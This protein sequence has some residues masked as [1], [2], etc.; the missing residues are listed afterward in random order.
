MLTAIACIISLFVI[1]HLILYFSFKKKESA[2][3]NQV[4][5]KKISVVI[6]AKNE[7][8]NIPN[9]IQSINNLNYPP[10]KFEIIFI[11]D[12]SSDR[13]FEMLNSYSLSKNN[14]KVLRA[15]NKKYPLKKG[16]VDLGIVNSNYEFIVTTD[17]DCSLPPN[18]LKEFSK[19]FESYDVV[20]GTVTII[21]N[22]HPVNQMACFENLRSR[23]LAVSLGKLGLPYTSSGGSFGYRKSLYYSVG[24]FSNTLNTAS[25]DD[26]LLLK[27]FISKQASV[28]FLKS[29]N[30]LVKTNSP[31]KISDYIL[32]KSRHTSTSHYYKLG[33]KLL[34]GFWHIINL[35][36]LLSFIFA[37]WE[38]LFA[39]PFAVKLL[40]DVAL[41]K[42]I[43]NDYDY[44]FGILKIIILQPIYE[45]MLIVNFLV[46]I[47]SKNR[48]K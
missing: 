41:I 14:F 8:Q 3:A 23:F 20:I 35:L 48:W 16:A 33:N 10:E 21:Q 18:W 36:F 24:G 17:A 27:E 19:K 22:N 44:H 2:A 42:L 28:G 45:L 26:D 9:L 4:E 6:A 38:R 15:D 7:E 31:K 39:L 13:T 25:G 1:L 11:D 5:L 32:Q 37:P 12:N 43:E 46:S 34:L 30:A 40:T 47:V 29:K